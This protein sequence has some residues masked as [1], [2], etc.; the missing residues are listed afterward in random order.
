MS[1]DSALL[2]ALTS[3]PASTSDI[4][5]RIGYVTLTRLGLVPHHA[6][7]AELGKPSATGA[8]ESRTGGDG[9]TLWWLPQ[10]S[11]EEDGETGS[12]DPTTDA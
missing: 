7:R 8:I 11:A 3:E 9:S 10:P 1:R 2:A 4:Y 5:D 6:L 12:P